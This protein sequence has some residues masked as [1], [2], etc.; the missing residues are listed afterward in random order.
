MLVSMRL[1][2]YSIFEVKNCGGPLCK[3]VSSGSGGKSGML[4]SEVFTSVA[5]GAAKMKLQ[6]SPRPLSPKISDC[7][8]A[9]LLP[10]RSMKVSAVKVPNSGPVKAIWADRRAGHSRYGWPRDR[11]A[12]PTSRR[13]RSVPGSNFAAE[14]PDDPARR[15]R[16]DEAV[17]KGRSAEIIYRS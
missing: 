12:R 8:K 5:R 4:M 15:G 6:C 10:R 16:I 17:G 7:T 14:P 2:T 11:Q 3:S 1:P 13:R 9:V